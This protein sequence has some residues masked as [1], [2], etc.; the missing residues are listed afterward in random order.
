MP[1]LI[2]DNG[3][4][5]VLLLLFAASIIGQWLSGWAVENEGVPPDVEVIDRPELM[6]AGRDPT[7]EAA[8]QHLLRELEANPPS[9]IVAPAAP[10]TFR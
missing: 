4:T 5:I 1:K 6:A 10:T 3:L 7:L 2:K 9:A 8:V